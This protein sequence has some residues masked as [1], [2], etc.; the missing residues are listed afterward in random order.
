MPFK[1][2]Y[3]A[4]GYNEGKMQSLSV[5]KRRPI[6][7]Q[8]PKYEHATTE[9]VVLAMPS[10]GQRAHRHAPSAGNGTMN[11]QSDTW[12]VFSVWSV[13]NL[14]NESLFVAKSRLES[15]I[16]ELGTVLDG[17]QSK[18]VEQEMARRLHSDLKW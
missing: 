16:E 4:Q 12:H 6:S 9:S 13:Q 5:V 17:R 8:R 7:R 1:E 11:T 18:I 2:T 15:W 10:A 3:E 14:Y